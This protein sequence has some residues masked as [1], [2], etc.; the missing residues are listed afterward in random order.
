MTTTEENITTEF[1][2]EIKAKID[3][4]L[5]NGPSVGGTRQAIP[6]TGGTVTGSKINGTVIPGGADYQLIRDDGVIE[7]K[8]I[9]M[10]KTDDDV[11]I[12]VVN[13]G[14]VGSAT[15]TGRVVRAIPQFTAPTGKYDWLN[16]SLFVS[17]IAV[18]PKEPGFVTIRVYKIL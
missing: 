4:R 2:F 9:Y 15:S 11:I 10:V 3:G 13:S 16:K 17:S 7:I 8:A 1:A 5:V 18:N 14:L 6:I 12:N